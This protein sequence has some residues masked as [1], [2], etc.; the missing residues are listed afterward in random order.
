[1]KLTFP[2]T[3]VLIVTFLAA[4]AGVS[5]FADEDKGAS[6]GAIKIE[7]Y[8]PFTKTTE[9]REAVRNECDLGG[10]LSGFI[11]EYGSSYDLNIE[12]STDIAGDQGKV[13]HV[14]ITNVQGLGGGAWSG[15]KSV[16]IK[17]VLTE[18]GKEVGTFHGS[19]HSGGGAFAGFKSS[20]AIF[21]R[22]V[23]ALGRDVAK[24]LRSPSAN[25]SLGDG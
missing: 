4:N 7:S 21:G 16:S 15:P 3:G 20:C 14:E 11:K 13:L 8:I 19:R 1:M 9:V 12:Q 5:A 2:Y 24:W 22:C 6:G 10:K 25:A 23:K 18:N 17:G